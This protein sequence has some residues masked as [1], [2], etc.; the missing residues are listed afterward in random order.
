MNKMAQAMRDYAGAISYASTGI[1]GL[2]GMSS[3]IDAF[4]TALANLAPVLERLAEINT[5]SIDDI[6]WNKMAAFAH[7][8][9]KIVLA[10]GAN[11]SFNL[12]QDTARNIEKLATD[13][14][15]N[16][17]VSKNLQALIA[18]LADNGDSATQ[19]IID[20][21]NIVNM[22]KRREDNIKARNPE[23]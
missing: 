9:G 10:Q 14:K 21:K 12:T 5:K 11:N 13:T 18:I 17:Q 3:G 19:V 22:I 4:S 15:A 7:A 8:G 2:I 1:G 23:T 6:P 16:L 20:G